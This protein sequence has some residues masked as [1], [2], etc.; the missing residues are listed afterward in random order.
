MKVLMHLQEAIH[1]KN[2]VEMAKSKS[3]RTGLPAH[4]ILLAGATE[5]YCQATGEKRL[6]SEKLVEAWKHYRLKWIESGKGMNRYWS[7]KLAC[8]KLLEMEGIKLVFE[9]MD[10]EAAGDFGQRSGVGVSDVQKDTGVSGEQFGTVQH[11]VTDVSETGEVSPEGSAGHSGDICK[12]ECSGEY[13]D[14]S[15]GSRNED[16]QEQAK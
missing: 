7:L 5:A 12:P 10:K 6:T 1:V 16:G 9:E 14:I 11:T 15:A 4:L 13:P 2:L 3:M 8:E